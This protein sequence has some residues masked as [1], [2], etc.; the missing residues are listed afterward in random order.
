[1]PIKILLVEDN[2]ADADFLEEL[3]EASAGVEWEVVPVE[4]RREA[5]EQ[6]RNQWFDIVL[7]DL[8]L[9]DSHGLETL[10]RLREVAPDTPMVVMTGFDDEGAALDAVRMGAQD[11]L[12]KGQITTQ[13]LVR[14]IRYAI[15]R[16]QTLQLLQESERRFRA[17]FDQTFQLTGLLA[18]DGTV[19]EMNQTALKFAGVREKDVMGRPFWETQ[20]W[21]LSPAREQLQQA[22]LAAAKGEFVRYEVELRG[23]GDAVATVDFSLKP[24]FDDTGKVRLLI[25]EG[26]DI[27]ERKQAESKIIEALEKEKELS[28]LRAR[29]VSM[30]SHE[31]RTPLSTILLSAGLLES[32][33]YKWAEEKKQ[34][35]FQRIQAAVKRM[36]ELLEDILVIGKVD[37]GK[38]EFNPAP[39]DLEKFCHQ[40]IEE[41]RRSDSNQHP[42]IFSCQGSCAGANMDDK[43]LRH[44]LT[45]LLSNAI[46]YSPQDSPILLELTCHPGGA[47]WENSSN[48][49]PAIP[50]PNSQMPV[51]V[52][53]IQDR[54]IGIPPEDLNR[55]FDTFQR[56]TN[57]GTISGT[58]LG[59]AI[60]KRSVELHGG[61]ISVE[62]EV[63]AGTTFTVRLP[64]HALSG[65][66]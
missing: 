62:S 8:S 22:I 19:L 32:Y 65:V 10:T 29:F 26:R 56:A 59:L 53:R 6:L 3:L 46:K 43:L 63:G 17:I 13:L 64:L 51:A 21:D 66:S 4:L 45:H 11:Y 25:A 40:V 36:T 33:S 27:S 55:I 20:S 38:L 9:P 50:E 14:A 34:T 12:V 47:E 41:L 37:A 44:I 49:T 24:V 2:P 48:T 16:T 42:L 28:S 31:F 23:A 61:Q 30:V 58:G 54:G 60:V 1:M 39:L 18:P 7:L 35:H 57:A 52:F 15:E 5:Q